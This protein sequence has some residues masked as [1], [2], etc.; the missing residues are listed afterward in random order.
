MYVCNKI[1]EENPS[2]REPD[3]VKDAWVHRDHLR[4]WL[5]Q[6]FSLADDPDDIVQEA[7][8]RLVDCCRTGPVVNARAFLFVT[9]RNLALNRA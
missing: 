6:R 9:A 4:G 2:T 7:Y 1:M 3:P 8:A 5:V